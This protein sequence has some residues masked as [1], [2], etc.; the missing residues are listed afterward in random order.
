MSL[1]EKIRELDEHIAG[2]VKQ[3]LKEQHELLGRK[4][5]EE[6]S[7]QLEGATDCLPSTLISEEQK[8]ELEAIATPPSA[9]P[10]TGFSDLVEAVAAVDQARSQ[11]AARAC[12]AGS[13]ESSQ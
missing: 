11:A 13:D 4:L 2:R 6:I 7:R 8:A 10:A 1:D 12:L 9:S 3:W 5:G